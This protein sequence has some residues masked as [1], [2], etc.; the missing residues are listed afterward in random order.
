M[1]E[2]LT[3]EKKHSMWSPWDA[4]KAWPWAI[5]W[6]YNKEF[7]QYKT[8]AD[9]MLGA[10]KKRVTGDVPHLKLWLFNGHEWKEVKT[11]YKRGETK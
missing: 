7:I 3:A 4:N 10:A 5:S 6:G 11:L 2:E 1:L 8:E 9:A